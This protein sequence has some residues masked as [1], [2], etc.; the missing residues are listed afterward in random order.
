M[1]PP[2]LSPGLA[3]LRERLPS[4]VLPSVV[5]YGAIRLLTKS[6]TLSL[7]TWGV[8][9]LVVVAKPIHFVTTIYLQRL[10]NFL[11]AEKRG[12]RLAPPIEEDWPYF[13]GLSIL[14]GLIDDYTNGYVG[15]QI[16]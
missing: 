8:I 16:Q 3:L 5:T 2:S 15:E 14:P 12:A 6:N 13:L 4:F 11:E 7:P 9:T 1:M 10:R